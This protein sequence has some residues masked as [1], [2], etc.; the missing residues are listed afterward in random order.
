MCSQ[1]YFQVENYEHIPIDW[2]IVIFLKMWTTTRFAIGCAFC[3]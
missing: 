1:G 3:S 2:G